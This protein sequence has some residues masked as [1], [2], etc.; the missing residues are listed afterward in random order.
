[1]ICTHPAESNK[2]SEASSTPPVVTKLI[3]LVHVSR[4]SDRGTSCDHFLPIAYV[5]YPP[6]SLF[7]GHHRKYRSLVGCAA[8]PYN[9]RPQG[10][11]F[12]LVLLSKMT[13][14]IAAARI[15][16]ITYHTVISFP[17]GHLWD[18]EILR[19]QRIWDSE[20]LRTQRILY[21]KIIPARYTLAA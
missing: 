7:S 19:T 8:T 2:D 1:M 17:A 20:I 21:L 12:R 18:S 10:C 13:F 15:N 6:P 14:R 16:S 11:K 3:L 4:D 5:P 9:K